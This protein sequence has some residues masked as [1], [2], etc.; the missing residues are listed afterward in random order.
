MAQAIVE[1]A[2]INIPCTAET[3]AFP[4]ERLVSVESYN[5]TISG[6]VSDR[7]V[8]QSANG[9]TYLIGT[10]RGLEDDKVYVFLQGSFFT[11]TGIASFSRR[12]VEQFS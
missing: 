6:F 1:G 7:D 3:G 4:D 11:T 8:H 12:S 2:D 5:G 10:V 9:S